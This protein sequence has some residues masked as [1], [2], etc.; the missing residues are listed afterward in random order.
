MSA[1]R[2]VA[3]AMPAARRHAL[4]LGYTLNSLEL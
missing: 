1:Q 4:A 2:P 3:A